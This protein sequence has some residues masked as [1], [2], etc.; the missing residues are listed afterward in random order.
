VRL[1][2]KIRI[3][4]LS[5]NIVVLSLLSSPRGVMVRNPRKL[6]FKSQWEHKFFISYC[7]L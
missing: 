7:G 5:S 4:I 6:G 1:I 3:V 2:L